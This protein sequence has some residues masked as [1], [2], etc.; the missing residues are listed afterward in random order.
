[1]TE[2]LERMV[3]LSLCC[4]PSPG[5]AAEHGQQQGTGEGQ[6]CHTDISPQSRSDAGARAVERAA[7]AASHSNSA[8]RN[9]QNVGKGYVW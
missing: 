5:S 1:M 3:L 7:A 6:R 2:Q 4:G 8:I 9:N